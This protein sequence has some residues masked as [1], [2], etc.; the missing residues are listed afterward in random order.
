MVKIKQKNTIFNTYFNNEISPDKDLEVIIIVQ[1]NSTSLRG[2]NFLVQNF[3][4]LPNN[5]SDYLA[6]ESKVKSI[7]FKRYI[8][9]LFMGDVEDVTKEELKY[10]KTVQY[11]HHIF[12]VY[13]KVD[14]QVEEAWKKS[15]KT[16]EITI[17]KKF[18]IEKDKLKKCESCLHNF[19]C[20]F[21]KRHR[22]IGC[23]D[24]EQM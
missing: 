4:I 16:L 7:I 13:Y 3:I 15:P 20:D 24:W 11:D 10:T 17:P 23:D 12:D 14:F 2:E 22:G 6:C 18:L 9:K 1:F 8:N 5:I 21:K 19:N